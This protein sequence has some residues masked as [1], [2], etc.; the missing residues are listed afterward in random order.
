MVQSPS[1]F[2][3]KFARAVAAP[4]APAAPACA[5]ARFAA[6]RSALRRSCRDGAISRMSQQPT[7]L[8]VGVRG[9]QL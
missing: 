4:V 5:G 2:T 3:F 6:W 1:G 9:G 7:A 8:N